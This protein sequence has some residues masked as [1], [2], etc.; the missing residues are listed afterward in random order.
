MGDRIHQADRVWV[1]SFLR[2]EEGMGK[3]RKK[4]RER[5]GE[6]MAERKEKRVNGTCLLKGKHT[7]CHAGTPD[8]RVQGV[9]RCARVCLDT[10][11]L[12]YRC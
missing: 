4:K 3:E 1:R 12:C 11:R 7:V 2:G 10:N 9:T 6:R 8:R 5:T